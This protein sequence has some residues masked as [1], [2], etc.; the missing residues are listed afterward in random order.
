MCM[1]MY[2]RVCLCVYFRGSVGATHPPFIY[3]GYVTAWKTV[4]TLNRVLDSNLVG[5]GGMIV[6]VIRCFDQTHT[7]PNS[8]LPWSDLCPHRMIT[9]RKNS[10]V[11]LTGR[12]R[13]QSSAQSW[14]VIQEMWSVRAEWSWAAA[15]EKSCTHTA[16]AA[17]RGT[18]SLLLKWSKL[19]GV[20]ER[21]VLGKKDGER[22]RDSQ[23]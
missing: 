5:D 22:K 12:V 17:Q 8:T 16:A 11:A 9:E 4:Y 6:W 3:W 15:L 23:G 2:V 21:L 7:R 1:S 18:Q 20:K 14:S 10:N 19:P 13:A